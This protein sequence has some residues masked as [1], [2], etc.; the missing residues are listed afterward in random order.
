M[1]GLPQPVPQAAPV[2][3][4]KDVAYQGTIRLQVDATDVKRRIFH[5]HET[6]PVSGPGPLTLL[7]PQWLPGYH[8]PQAPIELFAGLVITAGGDTLQWK[9]HPTEIHAFHVEVPDGVPEIEARF[10]FLSPTDESQGRVVVTPDLL[11][12]AWNTVVLYPAGY[13]A[14]RITISP[15]LQLP[16]SWQA[17]CALEVAASNAD[18]ITFEPVPLDVLVDSP[19]FAGRYFRSVDLEDT[20]AVRLNIVADG[21]DLLEATEEQ[22]QPHRELVRQADLLFGSRPFDHYDVLLALSDEIGAIG[23]EH[24]RSCEAASIPGY[25]QE[26]DKSFARRDTIPHE[27]V[28]SWNGKYRRG[29]DSWAPSFDQPIR[30]S[31]MWVYEGQTQYWDRVLSARSGLWKKQHALEAIAQTAATHHVRAGSQWRPMSD[32]TRDPI[33]A[34]RSPIPWPSWQRSEDYY[35]EGSLVWLDVDTRLR[36]LSG[37]SRSLNDFARIFFGGEDGVWATNTYTF[38]DVVA[39]LAAIAPF[40]WAEFFNEKL[41]Q[42][43][44]SAPL[45]GLERGGYRLVYRDQPSEYEISR[46]AVF[47]KTNLIFSA[48][49]SLSSDGKV[50]EVLWD[51]PAF[52]E[53]VIAGSRVTA[54]NKRD[55]SPDEIKRA[56]ARTAEGEPLDLLLEVGKRHRE[57]SIRGLTGHRY[58]HLEPIEGS[59]QRLDEILSPLT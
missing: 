17:G 35:T 56:V 48:G 25:F 45:A 11:T 42:T 43:T 22:I 16:A 18:T 2:V 39:A 26:W 3:E 52:H 57:V 6:I 23:V 30:N 55:F 51:S 32:T 19:V 47:G 41:H 24:H 13:F 10:Q 36:E 50:G 31:L 4:P 21:P 44:S 59:R 20:G 53:A 49:L 38:E 14:R 1:C 9:R 40:D 33:I 12:L 34:A 46:E 28:H 37:D 27:Y 8:S 5:A 7:Y 54:V 58:P 15:T 29:A